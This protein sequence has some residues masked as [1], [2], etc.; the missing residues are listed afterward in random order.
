[1]LIHAIVE[2]FASMDLI[3]NWSRE[4]EIE[5]VVLDRNSTK[6]KNTNHFLACIKWLLSIDFFLSIY[7]QTEDKCIRCEAEINTKHKKTNQPT[8]ERHIKPST[9]KNH[10][11]GSNFEMYNKL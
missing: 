8:I 4:N 11:I 9:Q 1:M 2:W 10:S 3:R 6:K 7:N 5:F